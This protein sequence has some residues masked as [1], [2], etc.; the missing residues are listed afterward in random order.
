MEIEFKRLDVDIGKWNVSFAQWR[1]AA[2][3]GEVGLIRS[4]RRRVPF[5]QP[6][7]AMF[8]AN[9]ASFLFPVVCCRCRRRC[10]RIDSKRG[11]VAALFPLQSRGTF[12]LQLGVA[13]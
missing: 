2:P 6:P 10:G 1:T 4:L 11:I 5:A 13:R 7:V 3:W 8:F 9:D 12:R